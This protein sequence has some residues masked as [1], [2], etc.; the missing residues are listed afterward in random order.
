MTDQTVEP[1]AC[2][3]ADRDG[4]PLILVLA[5]AGFPMAVSLFKSDVYSAAMAIGSLAVF[6]VA[7]KLL[8]HGQAIQRDYDDADTALA[9]RVPRKALAAVLIGLVVT[10]HSAYDMA[11]LPVAV[12]LG[13]ITSFLSVAAFGPDPRHDKRIAPP[14]TASAPGKPEDVAYSAIIADLDDRF[15]ELLRDM[16]EL[17]DGDLTRR[18]ETLR[19]LLLDRLIDR[20]QMATAHATR[21]RKIVT[22]L[23]QETNRLFAEQAGEK[24]YFARRRYVAKIDVLAG[25]VAE[26]L[27]PPARK[28]MRAQIDRKADLLFDRLSAESAG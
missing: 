3:I 27:P 16:A 19:D 26:M 20:P 22:L 8:V 9:P 24:A 1:R 4:D 2:G 15:T 21:S 18:V 14:E 10:A 11:A 25:K 12:L 13:V 17:S 5:L 6:V 23:A 7:L 28:P